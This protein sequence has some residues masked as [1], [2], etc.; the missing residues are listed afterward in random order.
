MNVTS[1]TDVTSEQLGR[2]SVW[3]LRASA[4]WFPPA[5]RWVRKTA[6]KYASEAFKAQIDGKLED[7]ERCFREALL[8]QPEDAELHSSLGQ[9]YYQQTRS[10]E[11]E[12][13][14]RKALDYD[15]SNL[16][17]FKGLGLLLQER[18]DLSEPMYY[19]LKYLESNPSDAVVTHNLGAVFHN[20]G[21]YES[22]IEYYERAE[23]EEA[24]DPL[25]R[26]NHALAL[27]ALGKFDEAKQQLN[28]AREAA[29]QDSEVD[30][31]LGSLLVAQGDQLGAINAYETAV[32][33]DPD[34]AENH[35]AFAELAIDLGRYDQAVEHS[36]KAA[37]LSL[38]AGDPSAAG[39]AY[40]ELGWSYYVSGRWPESIEASRKAL[41]LNPALAPVH[42]NLGLGLL[43]LKQADE[44]R[45]EYEE[46]IKGVSDIGE[47]KTHGIDDLKKALDKNPD[48]PHGT[49]ILQ[50]LEEEYELKSRHLTA[51]QLT[52]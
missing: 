17:A 52:V 1:E 51:A 25:V 18:G 39:E 15:Y 4:N 27:M 34:N 41:N 45:R 26:K 29:P 40:W 7:A 42:F 9:V 47:L 2:F 20:M 36:L 21:D 37:D 43:Q 33:K 14:F 23:K 48:L 3:L 16:R 10:S 50:M 19:Y 22:A 11:A 44:A 32:A 49:Q 28:A 12:K 8:W 6:Q 31:L 5:R 24:K 38:K 30:S 46:G 35:I 13:H